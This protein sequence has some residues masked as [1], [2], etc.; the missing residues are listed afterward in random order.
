[1]GYAAEI[2]ISATQPPP[3]SEPYQ[4]MSWFKAVVEGREEAEAAEARAGQL[5]AETQTMRWGRCHYAI[6]MS[7]DGTSIRR[8]KRVAMARDHH[9]LMAMVAPELAAGGKAVATFRV[10]RPA[11]AAAGAAG[12]DDDEEDDIYIGV[13]P[14][15]SD[16]DARHHTAEG[17]G[18]FMRLRSGTLCDE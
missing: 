13:V 14:A 11:A 16:L 7:E 8:N 6:T 15:A 17:K 10:G 3:P 12:H 1:M 2:A 9:H 5:V 4:L 18:R